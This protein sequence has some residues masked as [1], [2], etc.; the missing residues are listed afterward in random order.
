MC[1]WIIALDQWL[2]DERWKVSQP[3]SAEVNGT[4]LI[5]TS[6]ESGVGDDFE[7]LLPSMGI[8]S[9]FPW[10]LELLIKKKKKNPN[11]T[12]SFCVY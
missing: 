4:A 11:P 9:A 3:K 2:W 8:L 1:W 7:N 12:P 5:Y 10:T 6:G